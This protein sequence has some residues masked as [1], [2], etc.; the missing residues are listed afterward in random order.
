MITNTHEDWVSATQTTNGVAG[1]T[2]QKGELLTL[3]FFG[4]NILGDV[5]PSAP[6]GGTERLDPTTTADGIAIKFDGIGNSEDLV[7]VLNLID[8]G[9]NETTRAVNVQ[10]GDLIKGNANVPFPY[11]TE[12]TLDNNDAL[13]ILESNDYNDGAETYQIQGVQIMQSAN[14]L[15]GNAINLN[16]G[17][18]AAGD[19]AATS[20][21][22]AWDLT[23]NDVLKIVDIG[24]IQSTSGTID[25]N[26][27][28]AF[29]IA[30]GDLDLLGVQHIHVDI[31]NQWII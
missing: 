2:I 5:N 15:T 14:G 17:I 12:F 29:D 1:D 7:L 23:D 21:L 26:L 31:S 16:G 10:N 3:R 6:G 27:D 19:S 13:L 4:E 24:F 30:D 22:T 9:G 28:F 20:A 25:A 11:S 18:G 8:N